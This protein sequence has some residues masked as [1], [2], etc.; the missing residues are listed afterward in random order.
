MSWE[1]LAGNRIQA[2]LRL[3]SIIELQ[4]F[5]KH[6]FFFFFKCDVPKIHRHLRVRCKN[7][8]LCDPMDCS[9]PGSSVHGIVFQA[10]MLEWVAISSSRGSSSPRDHTESFESPALPGGSVSPG[11]PQNNPRV[12]VNQG[13][14]NPPVTW[15]HFWYQRNSSSIGK[16]VVQA[17]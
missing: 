11:S 6:S 15:Y 17:D 9:P 1:S 5:E 10:G 13:G 3:N 12:G 8:S 14:K 16:L 4:S 7:N 2:D